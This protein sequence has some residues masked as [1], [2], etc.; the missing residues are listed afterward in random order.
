[1]NL[2]L[3]KNAHGI[4]I[5][6][7]GSIAKVLFFNPLNIVEHILVD[8]K[9][10]DFIVVKESLSFKL[11]EELFNNFDIILKKVKD[12]FMPAKF[13]EYDRVELID[14]KY[15]ELG[16]KRGMV[17]TIVSDYCVDGKYLVAFE[18]DSD[19]GDKIYTIAESDIIQSVK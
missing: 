4:V 6:T 8:I 10:K 7:D 15:D 17:G 12:K 14:G 2:N 1:M 18:I 9:C 5:S 13:K 16:L 19:Q 3:E 11:E